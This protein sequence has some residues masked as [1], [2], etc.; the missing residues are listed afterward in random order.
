[1]LALSDVV[2]GC[3]WLAS[4]NAG[5]SV[6]Q[7]YN[8]TAA[9][10]QLLPSQMQ[11]HLAPTVEALRERGGRAVAS[12]AIAAADVAQHQ[13]SQIFK[14]FVPGETAAKWSKRIRGWWDQGITGK[15]SQQLAPLLASSAAAAC[16]CCVGAASCGGGSSDSCSKSPLCPA[17]GGEDLMWA[18]KRNV[19]LWDAVHKGEQAGV[20]PS[21]N[22]QPANMPAC[23]PARPSARSP[24]RPSA[25]LPVCLLFKL[26]TCMFACVLVELLQD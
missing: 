11:H 20:W 12:L 26:S 17:C 1:M 14:P 19:K 25:H 24:A 7:L 5:G 23:L 8:A 10:T 18:D 15:L 21:S 6:V 9:A 22:Q 2:E 4:A 3:Q 16:V 13:V